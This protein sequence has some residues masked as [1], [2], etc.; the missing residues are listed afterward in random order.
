MN[1]GVSIACPKQHVNRR[2]KDMAFVQITI[3]RMFS[4]ILKNAL[5]HMR[6]ETVYQVAAESQSRFNNDFGRGV[7]AL[8]TGRRSKYV[9]AMHQ[10]PPLHFIYFL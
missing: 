7:D 4:T 1:W 10:F 9:S 6:E 3:H 5:S 2:N 8:V